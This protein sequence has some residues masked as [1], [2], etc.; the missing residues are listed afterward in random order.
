MSPGR[1]EQEELLLSLGDMVGEELLLGG[2]ED[3]LGKIAEVVVE[4]A[5]EEMTRAA[6]SRAWWA[7]SCTRPTSRGRTTSSSSRCSS[8]GEAGRDLPGRHG[9]LHDGRPGGVGEGTETGGGT[10]GEGGQV[11]DHGEQEGAKVEEV[12]RP[13]M[14][15]LQGVIQT[16]SISSILHLGLAPVHPANSAY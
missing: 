6:G 4:K 11:A 2:L 15:S 12:T 9:G 10:G 14:A 8:R 7:R 16:T 1:G 5:A 13:V 3:N